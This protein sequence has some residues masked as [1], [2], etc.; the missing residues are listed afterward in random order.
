MNASAIRA[1]PN[2]NRTAALMHK[3]SSEL[4]TPDHRL[5]SFTRLREDLFLDAM[6]IELLVAG[7]E[8]KLEYYLTEEEA[9]QIETVGDLQHFFLR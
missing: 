1:L 6:D 9:G 3:L 5:H 7:L 2:Q 8:S 4:R